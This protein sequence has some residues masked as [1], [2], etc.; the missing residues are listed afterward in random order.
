MVG[1]RLDAT[2]FRDRAQAHR[3][4][5]FV[6]IEVDSFVFV[7]IVVDEAAHTLAGRKK[8]RGCREKSRIGIGF[9]VRSMDIADDASGKGL[10]AD[11]GIWR[12]PIDKPRPLRGSRTRVV[13]DPFA[14]GLF[15]G[16]VELRRRERGEVARLR[17]RE[18]FGD[19]VPER[20]EGVPGQFFNL[21]RHGEKGIGE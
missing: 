21:D 2:R 13:I 18:L 6:L 17:L 10:D 20:I 19:D 8:F 7:F 12:L 4:G 14:D 5:F 16:T 11:R 9:A 1:I 15:G 3:L